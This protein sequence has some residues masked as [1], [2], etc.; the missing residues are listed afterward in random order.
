MHVHC[1]RG[2]TPQ[3]QVNECE[4]VELEDGRLLLNMRNYDRSRRMRAQSRSADGGATWSPIVH[5][6]ALPEPICQASMISLDTGRRLVF[7][8]PAHASKRVGMTVR[9]SL[10]G[11]RSWSDGIV[12]H[13]GPAAYSSLVDLDAD[14]VGCLYE[15]GDAGPYERI[16]FQV[17]DG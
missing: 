7:S 11:G 17:V 12:L 15:C 2:S 16:R 1:H 9:D 6:P 5:D 3:H 13:E 8:N 4:V 10:D 14:G